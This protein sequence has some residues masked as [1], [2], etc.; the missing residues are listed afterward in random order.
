MTEILSKFVVEPVHDA[1]SWD[2]ING[3]IDQRLILGT[4]LRCEYGTARGG[5][6]MLEKQFSSVGV[7]HWCE[8]G[9]V[10]EHIGLTPITLPCGITA[11]ADADVPVG[12]AN[13]SAEESAVSNLMTPSLRGSYNVKSCDYC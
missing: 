4:L 2:T 6:G 5:L 9:A 1:M 10:G 12:I 3:L 11:L 7:P 13:G 8:D